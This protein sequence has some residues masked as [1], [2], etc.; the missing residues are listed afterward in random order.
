MAHA[1][2]HDYHI[3][4][5]SIWPFL[6]AFGG[7]LMLAGFAKWVSPQADGNHPWFFLMGLALVL[8]VMYA[9]W[10]DVVV[11]SHQGD[12]TPVVVIGLRYGVIMFIMSEVMFFAA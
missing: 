2:N 11:E 7:F 4:S 1:K 6:G 9:W 8:Y 12:H 10:S 3:L 5:P